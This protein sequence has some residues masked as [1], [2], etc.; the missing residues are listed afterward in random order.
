MSRGSQD[1]SGRLDGLASRFRLQFRRS[2]TLAGKG[3][4]ALLAAARSAG[5]GSLNGAADAIPRAAG[6]GDVAMAAAAS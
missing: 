4:P 3:A 1:R 6:A 5:H 2:L